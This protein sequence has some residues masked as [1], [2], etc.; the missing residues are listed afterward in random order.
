MKNST[1]NDFVSQ[2][3]SDLYTQFNSFFAAKRFF[4]R[5]HI[6]SSRS[7][8]VRWTTWDTTMKPF[9]PRPSPP[10]LLNRTQCS[11]AFFFCNRK[12][13]GGKNHFAGKLF[14]FFL[15]KTEKFFFFFLS[16]LSDNLN[17]LCAHEKKG[18][19]RRGGRD[20]KFIDHLKLQM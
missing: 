20:T 3:L 10:L 1:I 11:K 19:K 5:L 4:F 14:S 17:F 12:K 13:E 18:E 9:C 15:M 2:Q 6:Q 16:L 8:F 7:F